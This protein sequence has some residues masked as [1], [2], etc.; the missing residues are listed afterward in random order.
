VSVA[1]ALRPFL[2]SRDVPTNSGAGGKSGHSSY[3][4]WVTRIDKRYSSGV[5]MQGSYVLSKILTDA[6]STDAD[7]SA[8]DHYNRRLKKPIGQY[9]LTHNLNASYIFEF[10]S[11]KG[12]AG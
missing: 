3:H 8:L 5:T 4:A 10:L 12:G 11:E 2:R 6:D 1:Q 9:D 7:N